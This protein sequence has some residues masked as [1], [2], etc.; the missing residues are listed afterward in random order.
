M[1]KTTATEMIALTVKM[2]MKGDLQLKPA[3]ISE[4]R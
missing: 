1:M 2:K 3:T 4:M